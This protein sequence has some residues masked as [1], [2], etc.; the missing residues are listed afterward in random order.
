MRLS[1]F[2]RDYELIVQ[3]A[4]GR[5]VT[6]KPPMRVSFSVDKS[7][8]GGLNKMTLQIFNLKESNRLAMTKDAEESK[9]IPLSFSVGY[10]GSLQLLFK[11]TIHRGENSREGPDLVT[12]LEC[13]DGGHDYLTSFTSKTV[14]D[15]RTAVNEI[16]KDMPNTKR[17]KVSEQQAILRPKVLVG[18]SA[19]LIDTLLED[20]QTW[21]IDNEQL[22]MVKNNEVISSYIPVVNAATGLLD[23]PTVEQSRVSFETLLNPTLR[24][25]GL[26][27]LQ[28][29]NAPHLNGVYKIDSIG[30]Q[31]DNYGKE[32]NQSVSCIRAGNYKVL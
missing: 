25:A 16:L 31:G 17:G 20:D 10:N 23:T 22:Y 19:K 14:K 18:S 6:V 4:Q 11:G 28:S 3:V 29:R 32:W 1:R 13:L 15:K 7:V 9:R 8:A 12:E 5:A 26:C 24:I 27:E 2:D 21:Y 30:Y